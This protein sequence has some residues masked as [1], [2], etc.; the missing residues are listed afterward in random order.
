[1]SQ[2]WAYPDDPGGGETERR[3]RDR[4]TERDRDRDRE[5]KRETVRER[6]RERETVPFPLYPILFYP[7]SDFPSLLEIGSQPPG[8]VAVRFSFGSALGPA[9]GQ[10][11]WTR[12]LV[13]LVPSYP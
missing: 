12:R 8:S 3:E 6:E 2:R 13:I 1:V 7:S 10:D 5:R 4:E 11:P 9:W